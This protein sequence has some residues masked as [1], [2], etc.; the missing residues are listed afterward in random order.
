MFKV[1]P[2]IRVGGVSKTLL[3]PIA[4]SD[5]GTGTGNTLNAIGSNSVFETPPTRIF[6]A[7]LNIIF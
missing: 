3:E 6:G 5:A 4:F 2:K 7:T 1:A